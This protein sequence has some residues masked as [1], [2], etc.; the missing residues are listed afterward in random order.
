MSACCLPPSLPLC[1]FPFHFLHISSIVPWFS[2]PPSPSLSLLS[3]PRFP[4]TCL[5]FVRVIFTISLNLLC[6]FPPFGVFPLLFSSFLAIFIWPFLSSLSFLLPSFLPLQSSFLASIFYSFFLFRFFVFFGIIFFRK[7]NYFLATSLLLLLLHV[8]S[9][10]LL[11]LLLLL[12]HSS[13]CFS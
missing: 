10:L 5:T 9:F 7:S 12:R 1:S 6:V 8:P 13:Y 2:F 4:Y 11:L 3:F